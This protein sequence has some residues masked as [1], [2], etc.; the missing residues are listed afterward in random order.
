MQPKTIRLRPQDLTD[1]AYLILVTGLTEGAVIRQLV[2]QAATAVRTAAIHRHPLLA[3]DPRWAG[4]GGSSTWPADRQ[5]WAAW[6]APG[7]ETTG[8]GRPL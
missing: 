5:A 8:E 1:L 4:H 3:T 6:T 7:P 2:A